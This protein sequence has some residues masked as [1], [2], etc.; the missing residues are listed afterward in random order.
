MNAILKRVPWAPSWAQTIRFRLTVTYSAMLIALSALLLGGVYAA[1][2]TMLDAKPLD[3]ITVKKVTYDQ[4]GNMVPKPGSVFE[5]A[6]LSSIQAAVNH[7]T[8]NTLRN[9]SA[10]GFGGL[11][12]G[13]PRHRLVAVRAG[14]PAGQ[15][16]LRDGPGHHRDRPVPPDRPG[17]PEGRA[18]HA[19]G[20]RGRDARPAGGRIRRPAATGRRRLARAAQPARRDPGQRRRRPRARRHR[21]RPTGPRRRPSS[22]GRSSG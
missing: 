19:R 22:A 14:A 7:R 17:R 3:T 9:Y 1:L 5:A 21:P 20:H 15:P 6:E 8:L 18:A 4:H 11:L 2:S 16:D 13:Q 12:L 10:A